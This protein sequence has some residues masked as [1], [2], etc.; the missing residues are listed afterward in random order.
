MR[1]TLTTTNKTCVYVCVRPIRS[2]EYKFIFKKCAEDE[3]LFVGTRIQ[4]LT[5]TECLQK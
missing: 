3:H 5:E 2:N 1:K 4:M